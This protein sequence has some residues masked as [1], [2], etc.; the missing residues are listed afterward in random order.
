[1]TLED[2]E[3][4]IDA[5]R[6]GTHH[7]GGHCSDAYD[8]TDIDE[9]YSFTIPVPNKNFVKEYVEKNGNIDIYNLHDYN[10]KHQLFSNESRLC[11]G[12]GYCNGK[13]KI[14]IT[15]AMLSKKT[16]NNIKQRFL[17]DI[18]S[19]EDE[20]H[21]CETHQRIHDYTQS[22][23]SLQSSSIKRKPK[24][25]HRPVFYSEA[26]KLRCANITCKFHPNCKYRFSK[27]RP[28]FF[29]HE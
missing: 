28:C 27:E 19:D 24:T 26:Y 10:C 1:M 21:T 6:H 15:S 9:D 17:N 5:H 16:N 18:S 29:K 7:K 8:Y 3:I 23:Q 25:R 4:T 11:S 12:S 14:T 22:R 13:V 2:Y 20:E